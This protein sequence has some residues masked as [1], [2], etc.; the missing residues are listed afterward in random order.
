MMKPFVQC[1][2]IML[3]ALVAL[4]TLTGVA[5]ADS[6]MT[7]HFT[8]PASEPSWASVND[9]VMG[10]LSQG[11]AEV[12]D[13]VLLFT[14]K[15]SLENNGGFSSIRTRGRTWDMS[16]C[17]GVS[18]RVRGD[19][20]SYQLRLAS[21]ALFRGSPISY[22]VEFRTE[23]GKWVE[24]LI[25][26]AALKPTWRGRKLDGPAFNQAKVSEIGIL[27]GDKKSGAFRL[28]VDWLKSFGQ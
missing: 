15:I 11:S 13:G 14:G 3:V 22:G 23:K 2:L 4:A 1:F 17:E 5:H 25:P 10:G 9:G 20:R 6:T 24:V 19:G 21:D 8:N 27:L 12:K 18:L 28:E 7:L 16:Q 26:F